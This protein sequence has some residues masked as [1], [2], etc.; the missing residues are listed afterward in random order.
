MI[1]RRGL[2]AAGSS[3][4]VPSIGAPRAR[5]PVPGI[6]PGAIPGVITANRVI[7]VGPGGGEFIYSPKVAFGNLISSDTGAAA[8][9]KSGNAYLA[10][11]T[12]YSQTSP[13][14]WF[15]VNMNGPAL[16]VYTAASAAGPWT[17]VGNLS[18][19]NDQFILATGAFNSAS[20]MQLILGAQAILTSPFLFGP[21]TGIAFVTGQGLIPQINQANETWHAMALLNSWAAVAG[22]VTN[23]YRLTG[24]PANSVE[25]IGAVD[26]TAA[27]AATFATL[28]AGYRPASAQRFAAEGGVAGSPGNG[29]SVDTGGNLTIGGGPAVPSATKWWYHG[30]I[31]LDA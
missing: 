2:I 21:Y 25:I 30:L 8:T 3:G 6:T 24:S 4:L 29:I 28:P 26:A 7:I 23:Q 1:T 5:Q 31:S 22:S 14:V 9:D 16:T 10:G 20:V 18:G 15:A 12:T 13:G 19:L 27:T 11:K 17:P